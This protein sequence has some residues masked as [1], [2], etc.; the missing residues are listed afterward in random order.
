MS[1]RKLPPSDEVLELLN[2]GVS[3]YMIARQFGTSRQAVTYCLRQNS[4]QAPAD[5]ARVHLELPWQV[6]VE[7]N[8]APEIRKLRILQR[9]KQ[10]LPASEKERRWAEVWAGALR[11]MDRVVAYDPNHGFYLVQRKEIDGDELVRR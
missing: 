11:E 5:V 9:I 4:V 7:H 6:R 8:M 3:T 10:G 2:S 1:D